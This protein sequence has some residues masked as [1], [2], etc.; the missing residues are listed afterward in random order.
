[1]SWL[2]LALLAPL[3]WAIV[4]LIDDN[5][6]RHVYKGPYLAAIISGLFGATPLLSLFWIHNLEIPA[7]STLVWA[8]LAGFFTVV[9]YFFYFRALE[10]EQ[11]STVIAL[12]SL[13]PLLLP[14]FAHF[15][16]GENLTANQ[17][18][19]F[20]IVLAASFLLSL[21][22]VRKFKFSA[23]LVSV[24]VA[25]ALYAVASLGSKFAYERTNFFTGY[26]FFSL[27]MGMGGLFF[28]YTLLYRRQKQVLSGIIRRNNLKII[29]FLI[30]AEIFNVSAEFLQNLAI[31]RGPVSLVKAVENIQ[32]V[33]MLIIAILLYPFFPKYFRDAEGGRLG[34]KFLMMVLIM[35]G[36]Y[37]TIR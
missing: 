13:T 25:S 12:M 20:L 24:F 6:L 4:V 35:A 10:R 3:F 26:I 23:A 30:A 2:Y 37:V 7:H 27:G 16:V 33:Y 29:L 8:C 1:M 14:L 9:Y 31:S 32:P 18:A 15:A 17:L 19:G 34:Y 22:D 5:L 36:V 28:I 11:P 21:V